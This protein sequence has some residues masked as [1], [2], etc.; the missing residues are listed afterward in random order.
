MKLI[1]LNTWGGKYFEPLIDF[2]KQ[3]SKDTEIFCLQEIYDTSSDIKQYRNIIRANLLTEL[4]NILKDFQCFYFPNLYGFDDEAKPTTFDLSYG[5][6]I[7]ID[8]SIKVT[9][10]KDYFVYREKFLNNLKTDFS[11]LATP[12]QYICFKLNKKRFAIFNFHGTSH[13]AHKLDSK[14]R[15]DQSRQAKEIINSKAGAK[16]LVGDFNLLPETQS[17]KIF[18]KDMKN[19]IKEFHILR[20]RSNLSPYFRKPNF[21]KFADYT[22]VSYDIKVIDFQVPDVKIS[23]H[24]PLILEFS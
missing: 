9:E 22:F 20:T 16:I 17:I 7:F 2:I 15:I 21:Q 1:S 18:E 23:D 10:H 3:H 11:N 4:K 5:P 14:K 24:L 8:N 12:L 6:A 13:P 19:L